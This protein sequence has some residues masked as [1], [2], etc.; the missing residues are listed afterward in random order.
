MGTHSPGVHV[1]SSEGWVTSWATSMID[2]RTHR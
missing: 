2:R 1:Q